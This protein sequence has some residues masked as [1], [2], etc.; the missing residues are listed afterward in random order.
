M[1]NEVIQLKFERASLTDLLDRQSNY[2]VLYITLVFA[3][4]G[5]VGLTIS[6]RVGEHIKED[7]EKY[8][9][10]Y[11][12]EYKTHIDLIINKQNE[13][14]KD[15]LKMNILQTEIQASMFWMEA[16]RKA[17]D[18]YLFIF[19]SI[20]AAELFYESFIL[21]GDVEAINNAKLC[22]VNVN[23]RLSSKPDIREFKIKNFSIEKIRK[24]LIKIS[25]HD[26][27]IEKS[28][29]ILASIIDLYNSSQEKIK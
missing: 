15:I 27:L 7:Y 12:K 6:R 29:N 2:I 21:S 26:E 18:H 19:R 25:E 17:N 1:K 10:E 3:I 22:L 4:F 13:Y 16:D 24:S 14:K 8:K 20:S 5:I 23:I 11:G 9:G 28:T